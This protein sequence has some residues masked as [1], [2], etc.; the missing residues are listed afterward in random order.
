MKTNKLTRRERQVMELVAFGSSQKEIAD[1]LQI[2]AL[3]VDVHLKHIKLKTG[4][5]KVTELTAAWFVEHYRLSVFEMP[6]R[7]RQRIALALLALSTL[8]L[9]QGFEA[10][11]PQAPARGAVTAR[12][13]RSTRRSRENEY[14]YLP[15]TA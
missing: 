2:S 13:Q 6:E 14:Q 11:R 12:L 9:I 10:L 8:A 1:Q 3:T 7:I 15:L 5:Q 4:L